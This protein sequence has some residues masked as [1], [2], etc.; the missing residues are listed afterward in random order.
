MPKWGEKTLRGIR[1]VEDLEVRCTVDEITGCWVYRGCDTVWLPE[2]GNMSLYAACLKLTGRELGPKQIAIR[3]CSTFGCGCPDH[4]IA[5]T[6]K[7][8]GSIA[9]KLGTQK[10]NLARTRAL[11][12]A[13]ESRRKI[14]NEEHLEIIHST[15]S[16][17]ILAKRYDVSRSTI[18]R[19]RTGEVA[20]DRPTIGASVFNWRP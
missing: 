8:R 9:R 6:P 14:N 7:K 17:E 12:A 20:L 3:T 11:K 5:G 13:S 19:H 1:T 15:D 2:H 4:V 16:L 10:N 18:S